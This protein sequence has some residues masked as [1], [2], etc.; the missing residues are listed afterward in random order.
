MIHLAPLSLKSLEKVLAV[1]LLLCATPGCSG[2]SL[3]REVTFEGRR[4]EKATA[5]SRGKISGVVFV[6]PGEKME[7]ASLQLGIL[8]SQEHSSGVELHSWIMEQ[9]HG[10]PT[11]QWYESSTSD[12]ACKVGLASGPRP[13]VALHVCRAA[14]GVSACAEADE[15]I[16]DDVVGRCLNGAGDCWDE[17]CGRVWATRR[18]ALEAE[19]SRVLGSP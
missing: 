7:T 1:L 14:T 18:A 17:L 3:P 4:L 11:T 19:V 2:P 9:Y 10:S 13:F 12:E 5:W 8:V 15:Q 16:G 6:P